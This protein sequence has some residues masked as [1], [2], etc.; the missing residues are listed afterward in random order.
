[1][2]SLCDNES[3]VLVLNRSKDL[4]RRN[5]REITRKLWKELD[6]SG[7]KFKVDHF[8]L[9]K[10]DRALNNAWREISHLT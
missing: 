10:A 9:N 5:Q 4:F 2:F 3:V 7:D 8:P 6:D 1:M